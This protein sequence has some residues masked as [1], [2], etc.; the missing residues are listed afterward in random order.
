LA[1]ARKQTITPRVLDLNDTLE[2]MLKM[3]RRLIGEDID[4]VWKPDTL[5]WPV[6]VDPAQLDQVLA[7][8][9]VNA[10]DAI[11]GT[12]N[13]TIE[14][15]NMVFDQAYC[16]NHAGANPGKYVMLAVSDDGCGMDKETLEN[17]FE[18][19]FTTKEVGKGTG[20]GLAMIYGI[21]KQNKGFINVYSEPGQGTT[22]KVYL[23]RTDAADDK[24][25]K[26]AAKKLHKGSETV[27]LVEDEES[28]LRLGK[29]ILEKFG[30]NVFAACKPGQAISMA[31]QYEGPIHLLVTDVV[32]PEM[33]GKELEA[34]IAELRPDIKVLFMSG[35][36]GHVVV[37]HGILEDDLHFIPKPFSVESLA[38]KVREVLDE[39]D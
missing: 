22:F 15:S 19:F 24:I 29:A 26:S 10:R 9:C 32:M 1:F 28:I 8:L 18:P 36:T 3:L 2:G 12:G 35:Y 38:G 17:L 39:K 11:I 21:V 6:R 14:T 7:N 37:H 27:L 5:L 16:A 13:V 4:L 30:Y 20:L 33:D 34:R 25:G 31:E 23:P